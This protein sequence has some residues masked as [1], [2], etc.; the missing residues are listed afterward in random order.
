VRKTEGAL[1]LTGWTPY[2]AASQQLW[3]PSRL[4]VR[5]LQSARKGHKFTF[6]LDAP[7]IGKSGKPGKSSKFIMEAG[8]FPAKNKVYNDASFYVNTLACLDAGSFEDLGKWMDAINGKTAAS[9]KGE[10]ATAAALGESKLSA[11]DFYV[12]ARGKSG[13]YEKVRM[14]VTGSELEMYA[15]GKKVQTKQIKNFKSWMPKPK[16]MEFT[17]CT[18]L[19]SLCG[20]VGNSDA[21]TWPSVVPRR[22][23][24]DVNTYERGILSCS[25]RMAKSG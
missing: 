14:A 21:V 8:E 25:K 12:E 23:L 15:G 4:T 7:A 6:R 1:L 22:A 2:A 11:F 20:F 17:V 10:K 5:L 13:M 19:P 16:E 18:S 24:A 3:L 9:V